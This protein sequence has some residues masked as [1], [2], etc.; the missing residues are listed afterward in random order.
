MSN[1]IEELEDKIKALEAEIDRYKNNPCGDRNHIGLRKVI[2]GARLPDEELG[3]DAA[4]IADMLGSLE[5]KNEK[6][7]VADAPCEV[8]WTYSWGPCEKPMKDVPSKPLG[9]KDWMVCQLCLSGQ[10]I[11]DLEQKLREAR[12]GAEEEFQRAEGK[13]EM[14]KYFQIEIV[15]LQAECER[16]INLLKVIRDDFDCDS[17][18]HKYGTS[19]RKCLAKEALNAGGKE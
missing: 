9:E 7:S 1:K 10:N 6:L 12:A 18:S 8:C 3:Q 17:D 13:A 16:Y 11:K 2:S 4:L 14:K 19:C 15:K 5:D